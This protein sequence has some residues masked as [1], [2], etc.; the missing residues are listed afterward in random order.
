[1]SLGELIHNLDKDINK[2]LTEIKS[3][4]KNRIR[5][6]CKNLKIANKLLDNNIFDAENLTAYMP[7]FTVYRQGRIKNIDP[8]FTEE[9]LLANIE[10]D[11]QITNIRRFYRKIVVKNTAQSQPTY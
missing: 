11:I 2:N 8:S 5:L 1:M 7:Y 9:Y 4:G 6:T 3:I 10:S